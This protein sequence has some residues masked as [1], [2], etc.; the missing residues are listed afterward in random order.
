MRMAPARSQGRLAP[1][2]SR[3]RQPGRV[4]EM[5]QQDHRAHRERTS[6]EGPLPS[7]PDQVDRA[8]DR[9][10]GELEPPPAA[11]PETPQAETDVR[12]RVGPQG[13]VL[14]MHEEV[15]DEMGERRQ[16][17]P[18]GVRA[19]TAREREPDLDRPADRRTQRELP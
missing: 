10:E 2:S 13:Q 12:R 11:R 9:D 3:L 7:R 6:A 14:G 5:Q 8:E 15:E 18:Y 16:T 4:R 19:A 1:G 17:D